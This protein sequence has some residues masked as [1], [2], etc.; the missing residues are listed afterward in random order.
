MDSFDELRHE[1]PGRGFWYGR[2]TCAGPVT[3]ALAIW[4]NWLSC[5]LLKAGLMM[6]RD[7]EDDVIRRSA[8]CRRGR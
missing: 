2:V 5:G 1:A 6:R 3:S 8:C 7:A 4:S